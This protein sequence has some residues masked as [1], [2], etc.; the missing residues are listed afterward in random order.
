MEIKENK[1]K[2]I[3]SKGKERKIKIQFKKKSRIF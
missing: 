1:F 3:K 2:D